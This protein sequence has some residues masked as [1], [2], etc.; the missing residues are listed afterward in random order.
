M[1]LLHV[2]QAPEPS[3][4][5]I[6]VDIGTHGSNGGAETEIAMLHLVADFWPL[7]GW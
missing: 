5:L 1:V 7:D 6:I 4:K 3:P 2:K